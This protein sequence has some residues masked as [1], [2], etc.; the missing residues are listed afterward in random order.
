VARKPSSVDESTMS[1]PVVIRD[2]AELDTA[3]G[4]PA[5]LLSAWQGH[6]RDFAEQPVADPEGDSAELFAQLRTIADDL[7]QPASRVAP[8]LLG[9]GDDDAAAEY[10]GTYAVPQADFSVLQEY[11]AAAEERLASIIA[12]S[13]HAVTEGLSGSRAPL[14]LGPVNAAIANAEARLSQQVA[15]TITSA[16]TASQES[17]AAELRASHDRLTSAL[18]SQHAPVEG[19]LVALLESLETVERRLTRAVSERSESAP[20]GAES[21][22]VIAVQSDE[23]KESAARGQ[24]VRDAEKATALQRAIG[25]LSVLESLDDVVAG[26]E[27][28]SDSD[29]LKRLQHF[30]RQ[31]REMARLVELEDIPV[32]GFVDPT[33]HE[34]VSTVRGS[35]ARGMIVDLRQRGYSFR[36]RVV[37]PA[38]VIAAE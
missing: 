9:S 21:S 3:P 8:R 7:A 10:D 26:L 13:Q 32:D 22:V 37:R 11:I 30:E 35:A 33:R 1:E 12:E 14:D 34:V 2:A 16:I 19:G 5:D 36:G 4:K 38:Q 25:M 24:A 31:T 17:F 29:S 20:S 28:K 18:Q 27:G 6:T 23:A 15:E